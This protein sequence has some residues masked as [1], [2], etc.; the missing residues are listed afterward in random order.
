MVV[1]FSG[2]NVSE[3]FFQSKEIISQSI[4]NKVNSPAAQQ[5]AGQDAVT[6][7]KESI[8]NAKPE[9]TAIKAKEG[10][11]EAISAAMKHPYEEE[12]D[13]VNRNSKQHEPPSHLKGESKGLVRTE[14]AEIKLNL[15]DPQVLINE[16]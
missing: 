10:K 2:K 1:N 12:E 8:E 13:I 16:L 11:V 14:L 3:Q 15:N 7:S 4:V 5:I 6:G 9:Y